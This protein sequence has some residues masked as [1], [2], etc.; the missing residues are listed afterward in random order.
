MSSRT[1]YD[2]V[3]ALTGKGTPNYSLYAVPIALALC[4]LPHIFAIVVLSGGKFENTSPRQYVASVNKKEKKTGTDAAFLRAEAAQQNGLEQLGF[5]AAAVVA[6]NIA[7]LPA[8]ELNALAFGYCASRVAFNIV[9]ITN[10]S[11]V[12]S[13]LRSA[14]F[15]VGVGLTTRLY[16]RAAQV[17]A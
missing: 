4:L 17:L 1:F 5:F 8:E 7:K 15:F 3:L 14:V 10:T 11:E 13:Y 16:F 12:L 6:G 9:Y 2:Q